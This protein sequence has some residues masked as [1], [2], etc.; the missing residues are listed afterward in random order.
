MRQA[1]HA[2]GNTLPKDYLTAE[3]YVVYERLYG[4]PLRETLPE[5]VAVPV[6][7]EEIHPD[8]DD[9]SKKILLRETDDG[10]MEEVPYYVESEHPAPDVD[11]TV[12]EPEPSEMAAVSQNDMASEMGKEYIRA[13]AKNQREYDALLKLQ[14]D[15][16]RASLHP[17]QDAIIDELDEEENAAR[18]TEENEDEALEEEEDDVESD[19]DSEDAF[20]QGGKRIHEYSVM[21]AW[22]T[23]PSTLQL[24]K[25]D[26]V[27]PITEL[28]QR[29]NIKHVKEAAESAFGGPGLPRSV[30]T[31]ATSRSGNQTAPAMEAGHHKMNEIQA[32]TFMA[33]N[34]PGM[35]A[36]TMSILVEIRKRLGQGWLEGLLAQEEG[37]RVLDAGAGGA[38][39]A[40]WQ[41]IIETEWSL[42]REKNEKLGYV[43]PGKKTVI[44]GSDALR[45][46][47]RGFLYNT[48]FLPRLPDYLH[49]GDHP[50][51]MDGGEQSLP[52]K[53][54]DIIIASHQLMSQKE[55]YR[56]KAV[57]DNLWEMLSPNGG[58]I[59]FVE[60]GHPRGFEAVADVRARLLNEF[61]VSPT[62]GPQPAEI[63]EAGK[64]RDREQGSIIAPCT[65]HKECPMYLTPGLTFGRKD[66]CHF[67]QRFIRPPFLQA[68]HGAKHRNHEDI[69]F[70]FIAAQRGVTPTLERAQNPEAGSTL[71]DKAFVGFEN[72]PEPPNMLTLPRNILAPLKRRGHVTMDVC[73][74]D[75]TIERWTIPKSFSKK[76]YH[77]ARKAQWGDLWPLGAKTRVKRS[78]RLGRGGAAA[79]DDGGRAQEARDGKKRPKVHIVE[80]VGPGGKPFKDKSEIPKSVRK[81]GS[82]RRMRQGKHAWKIDP[83][84][85]EKGSKK[86]RRDDYED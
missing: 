78:V 61:I 25:E 39:L 55:D 11:A 28:L 51:K 56:R 46:R 62:S 58:I 10:Y 7:R 80:A 68:I 49:S 79:N 85:E 22:R 73:T 86:K 43:P 37:P 53:Q 34:M 63:V 48:S 77:D 57:L 84:A 19:V 4:A 21:G 30:A 27:T 50:D 47:I 41:K 9:P 1:K 31:P 16:E 69:D 67:S 42:A 40:A 12:E 8:P 70:S 75:A 13:I 65:N 18:K 74:P 45:Q 83:E 81:G 60:K 2:F 71:S 72:S 17:T 5:D 20:R 3:E 23:N 32:D 52:R 44:V 82:P 6:P 14:Q 15:F 33:I 76:A 38:G 29:T 35:Y 54:F 64:G 36:S 59:I 24:P 66:F 26:F